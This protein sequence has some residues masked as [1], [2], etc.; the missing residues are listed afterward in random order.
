MNG[1]KVRHHYALSECYWHRLS[2]RRLLWGAKHRKLCPV[3]VPFSPLA[4][5][6]LQDGV[7]RCSVSGE[8][9]T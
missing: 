2:A 9:T 3:T 1:G 8:L 5:K 7:A 6:K 4:P